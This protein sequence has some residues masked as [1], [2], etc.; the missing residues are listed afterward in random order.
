MPVRAEER[1]RACGGFAKDKKKFQPYDKN[2]K[3]ELGV[4]TH[5]GQGK[6]RE[7]D[8]VAPW[9]VLPEIESGFSQQGEHGIVPHHLEQIASWWPVVCARSA[10][11]QTMTAMGMCGGVVI[12]ICIYQLMWDIP[13]AWQVLVIPI[14]RL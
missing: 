10:D 4:V 3:F 8:V 2:L 5:N 12:V 1:I 9:S 11:S 14:S 13:A 7:T 6:Y